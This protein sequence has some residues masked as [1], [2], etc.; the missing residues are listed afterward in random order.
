[1]DIGFGNEFKGK[2]LL[3][4]NLTSPLHFVVWARREGGTFQHLSHLLSA[5]TEVV[6]RPH[7][8]ELHNLDL[9]GKIRCASIIKRM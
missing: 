9:P 6:Y 2:Q 1:M 3:D 7:V 8:G 4:G 5:E